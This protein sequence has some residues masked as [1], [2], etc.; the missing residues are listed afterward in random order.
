[1]G[2]RE[3][4]VL[5]VLALGGAFTGAIFIRM[6]LTQDEPW[7]ARLLQLPVFAFYLWGIVC[8]V[9]MLEGA[10]DAIEADTWYWIVQIPYVVT[11]LISGYFTSGASDTVG[12]QAG[13]TLP[14]WALYLGSRYKLAVFDFSP[15]IIGVNVFALAAVVWLKRRARQAEAAEAD[16]EDATDTAGDA[17]EADLAMLQTDADA[18]SSARSADRSPGPGGVVPDRAGAAHARPD[19]S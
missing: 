19:V 11:P 3:R 14:H 9:K 5:G 8:G 17:R 7:F 1:M 13:D 12:V 10:P 4:R 15:M 16:A 18:A 2:I 6:T